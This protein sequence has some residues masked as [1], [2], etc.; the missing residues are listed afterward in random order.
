VKSVIESNQIKLYKYPKV[1]SETQL[2]LEYTELTWEFE[3]PEK[4]EENLEQHYVGNS[5]LYQQFPL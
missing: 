2:R 5:Q 1:R 3:F 4:I